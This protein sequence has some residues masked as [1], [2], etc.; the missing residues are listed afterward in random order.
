MRYVCPIHAV[1]TL[2]DMFGTKR[3]LVDTRMGVD[4][5]IPRGGGHSWDL[6]PCSKILASFNGYSD[7]RVSWVNVPETGSQCYATLLG[8]HSHRMADLTPVPALDLS[9]DVQRS[10]LHVIWGRIL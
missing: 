7:T 4:A 10:E 3:E 1:I 2:R 5:F 8:S 6:C 9:Y